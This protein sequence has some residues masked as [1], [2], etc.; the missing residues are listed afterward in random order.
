[1]SGG[2]KRKIL[3]ICLIL[4]PSPLLSAAFPT[5]PQA[6]PAP[7]APNSPP[8]TMADILRMTQTGASPYNQDTP[9]VLE[10]K[11]TMKLELLWDNEPLAGRKISGTVRL[12][13][14]SDGETVAKDA[15]HPVQGQIVHLMLI[16]TSLTDYQHV[17][18]QPSESPYAFNFTFSPKFNSSYKAWA[19][20]T[21]LPARKEEIL[22]GWVGE[23]ESSFVDRRISYTASI[24]GY[25]FALSF[26]NPPKFNQKVTGKINIVD[27]D[28]KPV[29]WKIPAPKEFA[30]IIGFYDDNRHIVHIYPTPGK[31]NV[32]PTTGLF[33]MKAGP[34]VEFNMT[35]PQA[36][37]M[38]MFVQIILNGKEIIVPFAFNIEK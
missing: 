34:D 25:N 38:K 9:P 13:R 1:M 12:R 30:N 2:F 11:P 21:P 6:L 16:D 19:Y 23:A 20:V 3:I 28:K 31:S 27:R 33:D 15:L 17:H 29:T 36:G 22:N 37:F 10:T 7:T 32:S 35:P 18:P 8:A 4:L 5:I 24:E 26:D 14:I